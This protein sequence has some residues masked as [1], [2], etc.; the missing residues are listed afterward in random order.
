MKYLFLAFPVLHC[1]RSSVKTCLLSVSSNRWSGVAAK[2][3]SCC[4]WSA[5]GLGTTVKMPCWWSSSWHGRESVDQWRTICTRN[6]HG[7][8]LNMAPPPAAAAPSMKSEYF[9]II[10]FKWHYFYPT[11]YVYL[12]SSLRSIS[13]V[14]PV[15][16][17]V[18]TQTPAELRF[19]S[20]APGVCTSMAVSLLAAKCPASSA[21]LETTG[22]RWGSHQLRQILEEIIYYSL[23]YLFL[24]L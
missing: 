13:T 2:R 18:W 9:F 23:S 11:L 8:S 12:T 5:R 3:R 19:L 10:F 14:V 6:S 17:R 1:C 16:A 15:H 22:R 24:L 20:A 4:V 21:C 7:P